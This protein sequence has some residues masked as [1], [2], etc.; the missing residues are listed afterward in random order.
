MGTTLIALWLA[1]FGV[2]PFASPDCAE[3]TPTEPMVLA[4]WSVHL[5]GSLYCW[6]RMRAWARSNLDVFSS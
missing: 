4:D 6:S 2:W 5:Y 1:L 3:F